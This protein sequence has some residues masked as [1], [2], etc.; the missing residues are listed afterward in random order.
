MSVSERENQRARAGIEVYQREQAM[1]LRL[2]RMRGYV[3]DD[4]FDCW[5]RRREQRRPGRYVPVTGDTFI[6]GMGRNGGNEWARMLE[7]LQVMVFLG[8]VAAK[9]RG[10]HVVYTLP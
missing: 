1:F 6:L 4:E 5:F 7:L 10:G 3:T 8:D 9:T 2:L